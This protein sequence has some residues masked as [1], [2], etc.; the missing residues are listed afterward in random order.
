MKDVMRLPPELQPTNRRVEAFSDAVF[1]IAVTIMVLEIRVP[2]TLAFA[3]DMA[4]L[5]DFATL[6]AIYVLSFVVVGILWANHHYLVFTLPT[7]DRATIWLNNH[8]LFWVTMVPVV[9]RFFGQ[10]PTSPRATA[11]YAYVIMMCTF[12]LTLLRRHAAR[13]T[14]NEVHRAL[15]HRVFRRAWVAMALYAAAIPIAFMNIRISWALLLILPA[16]FFLPVI[17]LQAAKDEVHRAMEHS[18]P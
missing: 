14:E 15:H 17:R 11:A 12:A 13:V 18:R 6:L 8:V 5:E 10:H 1:A 3:S 7:S 9:A 16:L 4:A 2:D